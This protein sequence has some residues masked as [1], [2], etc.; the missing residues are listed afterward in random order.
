M[1]CE[2]VRAANRFL[3]SI[4]KLLLAFECLLWCGTLPVNKPGRKF[5]SY[6]MFVFAIAFVI[7]IY[8]YCTPLFCRHVSSV[9]CVAFKRLFEATETTSET[10]ICRALT[11]NE[12]AWITFFYEAHRIAQ[13]HLSN[14]TAKEVEKVFFKES[15][16][17][18]L[19]FTE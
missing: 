17:L 13:R 18:W 5:L 1:L 19:R 8:W 3:G 4:W 9:F 7:K 2:F 10:S 14:S 12:I 16:L 6:A 11:P 15:T